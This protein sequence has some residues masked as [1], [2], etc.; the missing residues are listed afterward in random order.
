VA[1]DVPVAG[2]AP[3]IPAPEPLAVTV[4]EPVATEAALVPL[5]GVA[6]ATAVAPPEFGCAA[7]LAFASGMAADMAPEDCVSIAGADET[8]LDPVSRFNRARSV[9]ISAACW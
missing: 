9:R 3:A 4:D 8:R 7:P 2:D 5:A 6:A 1:L